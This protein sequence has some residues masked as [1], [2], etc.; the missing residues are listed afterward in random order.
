MDGYCG[1]EQVHIKS[2]Q[3]SI[4]I[5]TVRGAQ[6]HNQY[7]RGPLGRSQV[8]AEVMIRSAN[9]DNEALTSDKQCPS[10]SGVACPFGEDVGEVQGS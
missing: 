1:H 8:F 10:M 3:N 7:T 2:L 9:M 5:V 6:G 4:T